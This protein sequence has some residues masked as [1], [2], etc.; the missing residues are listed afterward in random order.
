MKTKEQIS[1]NMKRNRSK[2]TSPEL[3]LRK[4]LWRRG[5]RYRKNCSLVI[6]KPDIVF[7]RKQIA[8][9]VD[10]RM[11][12]GYDWENQKEE[13]KT[14]REFWLPKIERNMERDFSV[15]QSLIELDW[16]VLRFWDF[17]IKENVKECADKIVQ[18]Y[19][20]RERN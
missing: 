9:F 20:N 14:N 1:R 15:T 12:H 3:L 8:V 2:D 7:L 6:G 19:R 17:E 4:E 10:G 5:L 16:I 18:A 13:F 11:W